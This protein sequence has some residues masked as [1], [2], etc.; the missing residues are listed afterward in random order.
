VPVVSVAAG[1]T[2]VATGSVAEVV[3][4]STGV[5]SLTSVVA[6]GSTFTSTT[7]V[8]ST[9]A[10]SV[11]EQAKSEANTNVNIIYFPYSVA[12]S[13]VSPVSAVSAVS[14]VS[15]VSTGA[16][17]SAPA[18]S[19]SSPPHPIRSAKIKLI[20]F[21]LHIIYYSHKQGSINR[22]KTIKILSIE[23]YFHK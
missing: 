9:F 5:G 12:V 13:A 6:G 19:F 15:A 22:H 16:E 2:G 7:G 4:A 11:V 20:I 1:V 10:G 18:V 14:E 8:S 17:V 23:K 3:V 21:F